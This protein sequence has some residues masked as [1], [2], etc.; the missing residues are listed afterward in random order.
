MFTQEI[1]A[2]RKAVVVVV[3]VV[4]FVVL[5]YSVKVAISF[6]PYDVRAFTILCCDVSSV[7]WIKN[8]AVCGLRLESAVWSCVAVCRS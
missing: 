1:R 3:L 5:H 2:G 6:L 8:V 4:F 7:T